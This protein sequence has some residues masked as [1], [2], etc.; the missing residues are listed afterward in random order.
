MRN[1]Q[2]RSKIINIQDTPI[3]TAIEEEVSPYGK[4]VL[5]IGI[6]VPMLTNGGW[7]NAFNKKGY[8]VSFINWQELK[9]NLNREIETYPTDS[10]LKGLTANEMLCHRLVVKAETLQPDLIVMQIQTDGVLDEETCMRLSNIAPTVN[11]TFDVRDYERSK[12]QYDLVPYL[13]A[14]F[15]ACQEDVEVCKKLGYNNAFTLQSSCDMDVY[16]Q[17]DLKF[18]HS[19]D[20]VFVGN[21]YLNTNLNFERAQERQDMVEFLKLTYGNKFASYGMGQERQMVNPQEEVNIYNSAKIVVCHN[22]YNRSFYTSDRIWRAMACG[23]FVLTPSFYGIDSLF[24]V[25]IHLDI[26]RNF[27]ELKEKIDYYLENEEERQAIAKA[28]MLYVRE[29]HSY[30]DRIETIENTLKSVSNG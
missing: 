10:E 12:W 21:R 20:I 3:A 2:N 8:D 18:K 9:F 15:F 5:Y 16:R 27:K 11:I 22:N 25:G 28:G 6:N 1:I 29:N 7:V 17:I 4:E 14:Y 19:P 23:A 26:W 24:E 13:D 30:Y